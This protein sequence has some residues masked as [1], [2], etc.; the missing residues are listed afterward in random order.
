MDGLSRSI[1][2]PFIIL[3]ARGFRAAQP[4]CWHHHGP[5]THQ[6]ARQPIGFSGPNEGCLQI[7]ARF[8]GGARLIHTALCGFDGHLNYC[9]ADQMRNNERFL[10]Q[11]AGYFQLKLHILRP[12]VRGA[13]FGIQPIFQGDNPRQI[14]QLHEVW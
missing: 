12:L 2:L 10:L 4:K 8:R 6:G 13:S 1:L 7:L 5:F 3:K 14:F 9:I 11:G